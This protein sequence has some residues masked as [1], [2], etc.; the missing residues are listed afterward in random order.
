[1]SVACRLFFATGAAVVGTSSGS[2]MFFLDF[3]WPRV[4]NG[5]KFKGKNEVAMMKTE[6]IG[7][8]LCWWWQTDK[9]CP[10]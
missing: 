2:V 3:F 9:V 1:L 7:R 4:I 10:D 5:K 8:N 6:R